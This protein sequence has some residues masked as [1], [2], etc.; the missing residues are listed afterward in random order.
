MEPIQPQA[1]QRALD[2]LKGERT[3]VHLEMTTGAYASHFDQTKL[4]A[5]T[6][7][8]NGIVCYTEGSIAGNGP[9]YRVG[10]KTEDGWIYSEGLTHWESE[11]L[12]PLLLAG[13]DQEG[14]LV[15]G[16]Q[17]GRKPF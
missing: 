16:L 3:Y 13:F 12:D 1:V 9:S 5:S 10:L 14:R 17:L 15:V 8:K 4:T 2:G 7:W 11:S 6:F